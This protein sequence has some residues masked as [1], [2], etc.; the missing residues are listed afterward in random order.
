MQAVVVDVLLV[1]GFL[2]CGVAGYC[3]R[4]LNQVFCHFLLFGLCCRF[5][6]LLV[7]IA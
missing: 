2:T 4:Y 3:W 6:G 1:H 5:D 7:V